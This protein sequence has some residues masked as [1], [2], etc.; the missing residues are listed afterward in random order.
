MKYCLDGKF[1][2]SDGKQLTDEK[3]QGLTCGS[4][5][6]AACANGIGGD[7]QPVKGEDKLKFYAIYVKLIAAR[8]FVDLSA[9]ELGLLHGAVL[10]FPVII[11]GQAVAFLNQTDG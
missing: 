2:G 7:G 6:I 10:N 4:L 1:V 5:L 11:A 8:G 3:D 9:E